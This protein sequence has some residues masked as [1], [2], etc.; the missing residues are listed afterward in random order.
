MAELP[1]GTPVAVTVNGRS[2]CLV[3]VGGVVFACQDRCTH[4]EFPMSE[5]EMVDDYV[6]ECA[7]HGARFDI[8]TG[9]VLELPATEDLPV[10]PVRVEDGKVLVQLRD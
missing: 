7:L 2:L 10:F 5:G 8:R 6:I 4:A 9:A 1:E 3:K